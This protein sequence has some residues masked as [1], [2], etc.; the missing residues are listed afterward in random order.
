MARVICP[1]CL[2]PHD[3]ASSLECKEYSEEIVPNIYVR[4]YNKVPPLWLVTI[5]FSRHGKTTYLAA[6]TLMLENISKVW[7]DV[8]YRPLDQCTIDGI[9]QMRREAIHGELP[10]KTDPGKVPRPLLFNVYDLPESGSRCLVMYDVAGETYESLNEVQ[11]Y[12]TSIKEVS[13]TWFIVSLSDLQSDEEGKA[14]PDLFHMYL[15]GMENLRID[16]NGRN[17]IVVYTKG[18][19]ITAREF[20]D[21]L[22]A[23][24]LQDLTLQDADIKDPESFSFHDYIKQMKEVS[25]QFEDYTRRRVKGGAAFINM[26]KANGMNLVFCVTSALGESPDSTSNRLSVNARRYRVLDPFLWAITLESPETSRSIGLIADTSPDSQSVYN[27]GFIGKIWDHLSDYGDITTYYMGQSSPASQPG[28]RSP[29]D[30]PRL[31]RQR[32]IGPILEQSPPDTCFIVISTGRIIDLG[33][34]YNSSWRNRLLLAMTGEDYQQDWPNTFV[35]RPGD[36][37]TVLVA[38]L[39]GL[40]E[41]GKK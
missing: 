8:Y 19:T 36:N 5:G 41:G 23:D 34:F 14:L 2:K 24:P 21:Y 12:V 38:A 32:L 27:E 3:F 40:Y 16:L 31:V 15:S 13:T 37:M 35:Y 29:D 22:M 17:L 20:R 28:Q 11:E 6:L 39:L 4:D 30:L 10:S 26:V 9:R 7:H 1:F 25:D 33:D 18:D